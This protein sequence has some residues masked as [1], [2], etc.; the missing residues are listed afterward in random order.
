MRV[1]EPKKGWPLYPLQIGSSVK[2]SGTVPAHYGAWDYELLDGCGG[3]SSSVV[4]VARLVA[5]FNDRSGN[6]VLNTATLDSMFD[7]AVIATNSLD[8]PDPVDPTV[9]KA[10]AHGYHGFDSASVV[11]AANHVYRASKGGWLPG[12]GTEV[13][14]R[15]SGFGFILAQNGNVGEVVKTEWL[16]PVNKAAK[17][18]SW[19]P[20]DLFSDYGMTPLSP[21]VAVAE[22]P[23][24]LSVEVI[25]QRLMSRVA[26]SLSRQAPA[27]IR[28][29]VPK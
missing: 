16:D 18:H 14:F 23:D 11:D 13:I 20:K 9:K 7:N 29:S 5:M 26:D 8:S 28:I 25:G 12:Q 6:P 4:D 27:R 17:A 22:A 3:L 10:S 24:D 19:G 2:G 21:T 1:F 15:T